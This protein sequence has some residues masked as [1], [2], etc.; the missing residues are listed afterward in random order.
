MPDRNQP[1]IQI[2]IAECDTKEERDAIT[3]RSE[4]IEGCRVIFV[5]VNDGG[6]YV[7]IKSSTGKALTTPAVEF[8]GY[9]QY[10]DGP[11]VYRLAAFEVRAPV[12]IT[13]QR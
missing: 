13:E 4:A 7:V 10:P 11:H 9:K 5:G 2:W 6:K 12:E 1:E 3:Q 8:Y